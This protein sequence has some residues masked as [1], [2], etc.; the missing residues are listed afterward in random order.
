ME[1]I[2]DLIRTEYLYF[3]HDCIYIQAAIEWIVIADD[4]PADKFV[5]DQ[6]DSGKL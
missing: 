6:A 3:L 4:N 1:F 2:L 5:D